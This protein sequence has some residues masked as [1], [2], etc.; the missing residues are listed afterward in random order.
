MAKK[1]EAIATFRDGQDG[2]K[3]Y[4]KGDRYP[5]PP[6]KKIS[7]ARIKELL[8]DDNKLGYAVIKEVK[9]DSGE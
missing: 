8:S 2:G 1:Y 6:N 5:L 3:V 4:N 9:E 7:A